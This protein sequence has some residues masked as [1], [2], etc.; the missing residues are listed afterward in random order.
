MAEKV[1]II[2]EA[3]DNAS[4]KIENVGGAL[5]MLASTAMK[6][7]LYDLKD[8][9]TAAFGAIS[10]AAGDLMKIAADD[11][12]VA[13]RLNA[14]LKALGETANVSEKD[15][16]DLAQQLSKISGFDDEAL[17]QGQTTLLRFGNLSK[18]QFEQATK[19]AA[20]RAAMTGMD[21]VSAFQQVGIALDNP[22]AGFGRLK[23]QIGDMTDA[24]R[25]AI[26]AALEM[27]DTAAAQGIILDALSGKVEGAAE[28][29]GETFAGKVGIA[30]TQVDNFKSSVG[31]LINQNLPQWL[32]NVGVGAGE[33][34]NL[35]GPVV[36]SIADLGIVL[37]T[38]SKTGGLASLGS[39]LGG[40][41]AKA[42]GAKIGIGGIAAAAGTSTLA[43][44]G[45]GAAI[46]ALGVVWNY[47]GDD[48]K[49]TAKMISQLLD[50]LFTEIDTKIKNFGTNLR[51]SVAQTFGP[52]GAAIVE[53]ITTGIRMAWSTLTGNMGELL[54]NLYTEA[55]NSLNAHSPSKLW[56][57]KVGDEAIAGG[58]NMGLERGL[59]GTGSAIGNMLTPGVYGGRGGGATTLILQY[60]PAVSTA[61]RSE[62][63]AV[64]VPYINSALRQL[65]K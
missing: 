39:L 29:Y 4:A 3:D 22:E 34:G 28:A 59:S 46:I 57:D 9:G 30:K 27:G 23:R 51:N 42:I 65:R 20:D 45:L 48:A 43:L 47:F 44:T 14:Q 18:E 2:L 38:F 55:M 6:E 11:E 31:D 37:M 50:A 53:G 62:A 15:I 64:I 63:E 52:V 12:L 25:E 24:Q 26:D 8:A 41:G 56:A 35:L 54:I 60:S 58:I 13:M 49:A 36:S 21:L 7:N 61:S 17:V 33:A 5:D 40:I 32:V 16:N 19:A 10:A 1:E